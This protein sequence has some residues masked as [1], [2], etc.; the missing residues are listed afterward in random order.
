MYPNFYRMKHLRHLGKLLLSLTGIVSIAFSCV[1]SDVDAEDSPFSVRYT[2]LNKDGIAT[3][4]VKEGENLVFSLT[5]TST[6]NE[7]WYIDHG[8]LITSNFTELYKQTSSGSDSL[9]GSAYV[10][11][12]CSFQSGV[13]IPAKGTFQVDI[14][15]IAD[16]SLTNVSSCS[17]STKDNS[18]LPA[19]RYITKI[20]GTIKLFRAEVTREIPFKE[21]NLAFQVQ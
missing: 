9:L 1:N 7:D 19:G 6:S 20:N 10:S 13:L 15:W 16:K 11:A 17:L 4:S 12:V 5:I 18:Y 14:P 3:N 8:S 21:Y 2:I